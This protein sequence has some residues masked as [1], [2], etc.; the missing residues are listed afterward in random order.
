MKIDE[1]RNFD[2]ETT[3]F[4]IV[5]FG[6]KVQAKHTIKMTRLNVTRRYVI[7]ILLLEQTTRENKLMILYDDFKTG[8]LFICV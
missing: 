4:G 1:N 7:A 5:C 6:L 2:V 8:K 3:S